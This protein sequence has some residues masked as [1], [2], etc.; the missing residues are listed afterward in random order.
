MNRK[1]IR[2][3]ALGAFKEAGEAFAT[4]KTPSPGEVLIITGLAAIASTLEDI[5]VALETLGDLNPEPESE[6]PSSPEPKRPR[7]PGPG[8]PGIPPIVFSGKIF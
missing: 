7:T 3:T 6:S 4:T 5:A 2:R 8:G 1:E